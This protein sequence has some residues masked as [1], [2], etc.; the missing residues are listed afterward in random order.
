MPQTAP[1]AG[2]K[3]LRH[4]TIKFSK[5]AEISAVALK[6]EVTNGNRHGWRNQLR[7]QIL[8]GLPTTARRL[9]WIWKVTERL[10]QQVT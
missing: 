10:E 7:G 2:A 9:N 1:V 4:R 6:H 3:A 8:E 5:G